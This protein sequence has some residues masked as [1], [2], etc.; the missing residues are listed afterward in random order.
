MDNNY[1]FDGIFYLA[2]ILQFKYGQT[3]NRDNRIKMLKFARLS[4]SRI[5]GLGKSS[6]EKPSPFLDM[7]REIHAKITAEL[8]ELESES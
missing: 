2:S 4:I 3:A 8:K 6:R 1:G 5:V 7:G